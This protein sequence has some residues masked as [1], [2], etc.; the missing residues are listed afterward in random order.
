M[1]DFITS[2]NALQKEI[3]DTAVEKGWWDNPR[4]DGEAIALM[5]SELSEALEALRHGNGPDDKVPEFSGVEVE[6]ADT[7]IRIMDLAAGR[8]WRVA[9]AIQAKVA[10]NKTRER[11]HGG[12]KF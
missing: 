9:E 10:M 1:T 7:V 6:L 5:H 11:M 12:K 3:H 8:G 2:F 4:N